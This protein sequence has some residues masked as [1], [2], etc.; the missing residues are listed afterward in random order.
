AGERGGSSRFASRSSS[1]LRSSPRHSS[2]GSPDASGAKTGESSLRSTAPPRG[3]VHG[4]GC[5]AER[6]GE[7]SRIGAGGTGAAASLGRDGRSL[8]RWAFD[9]KG[10]QLSSATAAGK[11]K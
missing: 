8:G 6:S 9:R 11:G 3:E 10:L 1:V 4:A 7:R 2:S 5:A